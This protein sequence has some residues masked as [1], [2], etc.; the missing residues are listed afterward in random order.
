M[1]GLMRTLAYYHTQL[2]VAAVHTVVSFFI[3]ATVHALVGDVSLPTCITS[4]QLCSKAP[5]LLH[6]LNIG[7]WILLCDIDIVFV[8]LMQIYFNMYP[9]LLFYIF[10]CLFFKTQT[11]GMSTLH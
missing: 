2:E 6:R 5:H 1:S 4:L 3:L 9:V 11:S 8:M 10:C 7:N